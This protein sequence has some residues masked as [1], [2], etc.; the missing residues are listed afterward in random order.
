MQACSFSEE[1]TVLD[2]PKGV[3]QSDCESISV[4]TG[5]NTQ[6]V[7][8]TVS[9]WKVTKEEL[10]QIQSTGRVWLVVM[11]HTMPPVYM[12]TEKPIE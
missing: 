1:N 7:P 10:E 9:C 4:W 8:V 3:K 5:Y 2:P 12:T 11:G 6:G